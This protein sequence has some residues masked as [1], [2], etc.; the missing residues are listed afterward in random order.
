MPR[1]QSE[2]ALARRGRSGTL[3]NSQWEFAMADND[4]GNNNGLY[5]LVGGL[6]VVVGIIAF[7][8]FD[9]GAP[10]TTEQTNVTIEAAPTTSTPEP[11]PEPV[12]APTTNTQ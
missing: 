6:V 1:S 5:F 10:G 4:G 7:V 3:C 11:A 2:P 8:Y 12:P 9:G